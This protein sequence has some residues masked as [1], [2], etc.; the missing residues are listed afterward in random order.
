MDP[1]SLLCAARDL[2]LGGS[3]AACGRPGSVLCRECR[4]VLRASAA[5]TAGPARPDPSPGGLGPVWAA[6]R[7]DGPLRSLVLAH[8]EHGQQALA[9]PLGELLAVAV[10]GLLD[11]A[12]APAGPVV[13][14]P[15]PSRPAATRE[16]GRD[17]TLALVRAAALRLRR[18]AGRDGRD[19]RLA[20]LL[21]T[22]PGVVDQ[23]GLDHT[24]R[25]ENLRGSMRVAAGALRTLAASS[26][27][28]G[29][30]VVCDDV[31]TTGSSLVEAAR[32]LRSVG[33]DP[34]GSA[35]VGA[36]PRRTRMKGF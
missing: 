25:A 8:K 18:D 33:L 36:T 27:S 35:T 3:C 28:V 1:T 5:T 12:A 31:V 17:P 24:R 29:A 26:P 30:V 22:R 7:Y 11:R 21:V 13:L 23:A 6:A 2:L 32:A 19:V 9:R 15:V 14:V 10:A 16:R 20:R 4:E 34:T